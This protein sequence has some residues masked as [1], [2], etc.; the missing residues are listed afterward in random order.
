MSSPECLDLGRPAFVYKILMADDWRADTPVVPTTPLDVK[1]GFIHL[2]I[3]PQIAGVLERYFGHDRDLVCLRFSCQTLSQQ[4]DG[5]LL[6]WE[7]SQNGEVF[8][9]FYGNL[10]ASWSDLQYLIPKDR[11]SRNTLLRHLQERELDEHI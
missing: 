3:G 10:L 4:G 7:M 8:P 9:H 2:A 5:C 11:A 6:R 1:D